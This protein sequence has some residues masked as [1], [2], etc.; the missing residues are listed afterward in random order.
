MPHPVFAEH[1]GAHARPIAAGGRSFRSASINEHHL[2]SKNTINKVALR[3]S[4]S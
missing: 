1:Q 2:E 3:N 4:D